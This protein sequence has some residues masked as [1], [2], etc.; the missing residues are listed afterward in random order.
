MTS[1]ENARASAMLIAVFP[2]AVGPTSTI[3]F[4]SGICGRALFY[5][6]LW[7][8]LYVSL[9]LL[10]FLMHEDGVHELHLEKDRK[11]KKGP[12]T[13]PPSPQEYPE[14][15]E[16]RNTYQKAQDLSF[17]KHKMDV[18][19]LEIARNNAAESLSPQLLEKLEDQLDDL[20]SKHKVTQQSTQKERDAFFGK[21]EKKITEME[22]QL[23]PAP[24]SR[25]IEI[26]GPQVE[27]V[28]PSSRNGGGARSRIARTQTP[29]ISLAGGISAAGVSR[30]ERVSPPASFETDNLS[31]ADVAERAERVALQIY[32]NLLDVDTQTFQSLLERATPEEKAAVQNPDLLDDPQSRSYLRALEKARI[33]LEDLEERGTPVPELTPE[34]PF[35]RS[36]VEQRGATRSKGFMGMEVQTP[37][38]TA[39]RRAPQRAQGA[40][41]LPAASNEFDEYSGPLVSLPSKEVA[42]WA[43]E[44][45][46]IADVENFFTKYESLLQDDERREDLLSQE[47]QAF[48]ATHDAQDVIAVMQSGMQ[49]STQPKSIFGRVKNLFSQPARE[50]KVLER[51]V[52]EFRDLLLED[53]APTGESLKSRRPKSRRIQKTPGIS[54][55]T[56]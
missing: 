33:A 16:D 22:R 29:A 40:E 39:V 44:S 27:K 23:T 38:R 21:L 37:P 52:D 17:I 46:G 41:P 49:D 32:A 2:E 45:F 15:P 12:E 4:G 24:R 20:R 54:G 36:K 13:Q 11:L 9:F 47:A 10:V 28:T 25:K 42:R 30:Y 1:P 14:T 51:V 5:T 43:Q 50:M 56:K 55:I 53:T 31:E 6:V 3:I 34:T 18:I 48:L 19:S 26:V 8:I 35:P 7:F